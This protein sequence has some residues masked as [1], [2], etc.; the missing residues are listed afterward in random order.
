[1]KKPKEGERS[2]KMAESKMWPTAAGNVFVDSHPDS[3]TLRCR[4]I[5]L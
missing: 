4:F 5:L 2:K 3:A 1:M